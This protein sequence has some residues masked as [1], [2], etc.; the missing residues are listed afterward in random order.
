MNLYRGAAEGKGRDVIDDSQ[1]LRVEEVFQHLGDMFPHLGE[2][3]LVDA[4]FESRELVHG[5]P[6]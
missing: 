4:V 5:P 6:P 3:R 1:V 2:E